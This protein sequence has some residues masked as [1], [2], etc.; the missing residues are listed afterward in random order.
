[1]ATTIQISEELKHELEKKKFT[2][3]ETYEDVIWDLIEDSQELSE[4]T[5]RHIA[6][7]E[8]EIRDGKLV[9]LEEVKKKFGL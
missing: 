1:M 5:K 6:Q 2:A 4:E 8:Q 9:P 7:S 3:R